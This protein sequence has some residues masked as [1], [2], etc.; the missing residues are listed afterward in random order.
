MEDWSKKFGADKCVS[1]LLVLFVPSVDRADQP[2]DHDGWVNKA[3]EFLGVHLKGGTAFPQGWA[4]GGMTS[5]A[6]G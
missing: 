3:L 6:G 2:I 5:K 1:T 4:C